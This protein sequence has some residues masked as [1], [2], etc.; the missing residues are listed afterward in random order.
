MTEKP[1]ACC[2]VAAN[3]E[4]KTDDDRPELAVMVCRLCGCRHFELAVDPGLMLATG[5]DA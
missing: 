2:N 3:L 5:K 4:N 1:N